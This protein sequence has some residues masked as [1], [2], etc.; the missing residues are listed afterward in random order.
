MFDARMEIQTVTRKGNKSSIHL[1]FH[2]TKSIAQA[3][4]L[5]QVRD[6]VNNQGLDQDSGDYGSDVIELSMR[7]CNSF[8]FMGWDYVH[9]V[10]IRIQPVGIMQAD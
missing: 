4:R 9:T 3:A 5:E 10:T 6:Y 2:Q 1:S 7:P 8:E